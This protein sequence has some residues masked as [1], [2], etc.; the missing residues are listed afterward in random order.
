[1][2]LKQRK[3]LFLVNCLAEKNSEIDL[4]KMFDLFPEEFMAAIYLN[5]I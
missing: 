2:Y 5:N 1:M 3:A 4:K